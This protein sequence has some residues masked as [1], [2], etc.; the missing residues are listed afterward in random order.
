LP[1]RWAFGCAHLRIG[2]LQYRG[3][4]LGMDASS[5]SGGGG[6]EGGRGGRRWKGKGVT[7]IQ[8]RRQLAPVMEDASAASLR[9][10]KKIGRG[11]DRFQRSASSLSTSSSAPPSPRASAASAAAAAAASPPSARRI[12]PFAY[13]TSALAGGAA[14][15]LQLPPW[16]HS[17]ASP[18]RLQAPP[19]S[20]QMISFGAPPQYQAQLLLPADG[21]PQ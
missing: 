19:Q 2:A 7:P 20:Q 4:R 21:S 3:R 10:L 11:P 14:P 17:S 8:P 15:R 18:P 16:Q 5:A 6:T 13:E 1:G 12:F 9:P